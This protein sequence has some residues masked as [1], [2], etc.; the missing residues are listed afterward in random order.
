MR[1]IILGVLVGLC[2][3]VVPDATFASMITATSSG[4]T[5]AMY[6][7]EVRAYFTDLPVMIDIAQCESKFR[8]FTDA[9]SVFYGG[10]GQEYIGIFQFAAAIHTVPARDLGFDLAT[11]EGNL[12]YARHVYEQSG[13][14]PWQSCV[15]APVAADATLELRITLMKTLIGLLQQLLT[16][17]L[18]EGS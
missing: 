14:V 16:L 11:V 17:K 12:A 13:T 15:P 8:Q 2:S 9:G 5:K 3:V 6:E 10:A 1:T 4:G 7:S 18:A